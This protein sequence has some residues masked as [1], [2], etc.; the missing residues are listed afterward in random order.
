MFRQRLTKFKG[1]DLTHDTADALK[2]LE[3]RAW[4]LGKWRVK[5]HAQDTAGFD[6]MPSEIRNTSMLIAGREVHMVLEHESANPTPQRS[7]EALWGFS[8]PLGFT[9]YLRYPVEDEEGSGVFHFFGPWETLKDR[10]LAEGR[11]HL[12]WPS[13][14]AAA[15]TDVGTWKGDQE[16]PRFIQ[17]QLHRLGRNVGPID[18][19]IGSRTRAAI[20]T[21][22][23]QKPSIARVAE[24][25]KQTNPPPH[26]DQ[27]HGKGHLVLPGK[28]LNIV[29]YGKVS[30]VRTTHGAT[31]DVHGSGRLVVDIS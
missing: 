9:P 2:A 25:V 15:Q 14:C 6:T 28:T 16:I 3:E 7:L 10:L 20:E 11:G 21:L 24:Y 5:F 29:S 26:P 22:G 13:V 30:A 12:A 19:S 4:E 27:T 31:F 17:G 23:I 1:L 18:G 8:V